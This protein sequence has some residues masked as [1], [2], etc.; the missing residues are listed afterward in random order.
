MAICI[1]VNSFA[2][3]IDGDWPS[4]FPISFHLYRQLSFSKFIYLFTVNTVSRRSRRTW[5][6]FIE[7]Q[8]SYSGFTN[9]VITKSVW[10]VDLT[11]ALVFL[12]SIPWPLFPNKWSK[13]STFNY[14]AYPGN[15]CGKQQSSPQNL[16]N[17]SEHTSTPI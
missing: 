10:V 6:L 16:L 13:L 9:L 17:V 3:L 2:H 4:L 14:S 15:S 8:K 11:L 12:L 1:W 7:L 5:T